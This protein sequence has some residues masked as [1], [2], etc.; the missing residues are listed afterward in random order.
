MRGKETRPGLEFSDKIEEF[1]VGSEVERQA[2]ELA[3]EKHRGVLRQ[4]GSEYFT[5]CV[6]TA[7][8]LKAWGLTDESLIAAA[9]MHDLVEDTDVTLTELRQRFGAQIA[10]WVDGV[11]KLKSRDGKSDEN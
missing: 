11:S 2:F 10:R 7:S 5:H 9:L 6:A 4:D 8:I 1:T 3:R